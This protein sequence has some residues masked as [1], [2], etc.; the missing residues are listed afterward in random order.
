[1]T[2]NPKLRLVRESEDDDARTVEDKGR[3]RKPCLLSAK[4]HPVIEQCS[5]QDVT[6][7][8]KT[9]HSGALSNRPPVASHSFSA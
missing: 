8:L 5:R 2:R 1:M 3:L 6:G 9:G 4:V 7:R